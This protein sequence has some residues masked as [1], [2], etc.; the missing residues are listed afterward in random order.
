MMWKIRKKK[1]KGVF[2]CELCV[3]RRAMTNVAD[4]IN[5]GIEIAESCEYGSQEA[6]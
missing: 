2:Q 1:V 4:N 3:L 5:D 6:S